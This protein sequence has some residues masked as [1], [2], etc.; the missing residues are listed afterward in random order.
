MP[1]VLGVNAPRRWETAKP[2][3]AGSGVTPA[4]TGDAQPGANTRRRAMPH[5]EMVREGGVG[6]KRR[7]SPDAARRRG[8]CPT[9]R[10]HPVGPAELPAGGER[11]CR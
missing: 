9:G 8:H 2:P 3:R 7:R 10:R 6:N 11:A 5:N 1:A 4:R